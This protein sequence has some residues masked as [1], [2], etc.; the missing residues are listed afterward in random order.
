[1]VVKKHLNNC[2]QILKQSVVKK[3]PKILFDPNKKDDLGFLVAF[4]TVSKALEDK[5]ITKGTL[6]KKLRS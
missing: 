1:M 4:T 2:I 6:N 3:R 5:V